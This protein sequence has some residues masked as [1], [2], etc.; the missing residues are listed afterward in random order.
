MK[1]LSSKE[2]SFK[3]CRFSEEI[4]KSCILSFTYESCGPHI[5]GAV[6]VCR[7]YYS[8]LITLTLREL[9]HY[10]IQDIFILHVRYAQFARLLHTRL[11]PMI[12]HMPVDDK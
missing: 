12:A 5:L 1:Y 9:A 11:A 7:R 3:K 10:N 6:F 4:R 8:A 2:S